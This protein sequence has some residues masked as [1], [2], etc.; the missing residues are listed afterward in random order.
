MKLCSMK[1]TFGSVIL[2]F[3]KTYTIL[4]GRFWHSTIIRC[5][6]KYNTPVAQRIYVAIRY[7]FGVRWA[8]KSD[9]VTHEKLTIHHHRIRVKTKS[10]GETIG[11]ISLYVRNSSQSYTLKI[12]AFFFLLK[13]QKQQYSKN[14]IRR[15][16]ICNTVTAYAHR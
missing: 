6:C 3:L 5:F 11:W 13:S 8:E 1:S 9:C 15:Y 12:I 14:S 7:A 16:T 2:A 10:K 4:S